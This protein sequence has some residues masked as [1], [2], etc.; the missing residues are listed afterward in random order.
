MLVVLS[1]RMLDDGEPSSRSCGT[2]SVQ[3]ASIFNAFGSRVEIFET[4]PRILPAEDKDVA[5]AVATRARFP[6]I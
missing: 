4:G 5:A 1:A 6:L 2:T 3:V